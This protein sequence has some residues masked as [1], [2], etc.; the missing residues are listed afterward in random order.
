MR[1]RQIFCRSSHGLLEPLI[2]GKGIRPHQLSLWEKSLTQGTPLDTGPGQWWLWRPV[3]L[4][5]YFE[6]LR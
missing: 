4:L 6:Y 5:T 3:R 2:L 1:I